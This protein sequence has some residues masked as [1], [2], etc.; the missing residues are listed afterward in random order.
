[1]NVPFPFANSG[2]TVFSLLF[3]WNA[4]MSFCVVIVE[5]PSPQD[6]FEDR[7]EG[8]L[9]Q[10]CLKL[11]N[12][13]CILR[14]VLDA[15]HLSKAL[16]QGIMGLGR[17]PD[18][19]PILHISAH[20]N[21]KGI[22]LTNGCFMLWDELIGGLSFMNQQL[23]GQL[24][25]CMS[26]CEGYSCVLDASRSAGYPPWKAFVGNTTR[27]TWAEAAIGFSA[28]YHLLNKGM[29]VRNAVEG[30]KAAS[31]NQYYCAIDGDDLSEAP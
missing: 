6:F 19:L 4:D 29:T 16:T 9:I 21:Q 10:A 13:R 12:I 11:A 24:I 30:M 3:S 28:F 26:S 8:R 31:G 2:C 5:S 1:M 22:E 7:A 14:T 17:E 20:G 18:V 27:P 25:V 15:P 23:H